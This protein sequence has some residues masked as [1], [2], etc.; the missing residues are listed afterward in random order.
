MG[1]GTAAQRARAGLARAAKAIKRRVLELA[2]ATDRGECL[3]DGTVN[4]D[5][6]LDV[7]HVPVLLD[8]EDEDD[9]LEE[10]TLEPVSN[11]PEDTE[12]DDIVELLPHETLEMI[13]SDKKGEDGGMRERN[14]N[15]VLKKRASDMSAKE[16]K[17]VEKN[18]ALGYNGQSR[19]WTNE[20]IR[21]ARKQE[22]EDAKTRNSAPAKM[23]RQ[24]FAPRPKPPV[25]EPEPTPVPSDSRPTSPI[26]VYDSDVSDLVEYDGVICSTVGWLKDAS[27]TLEY[28]KNYEGYW[29]GELFIKQIIEKIIP[30]FEAAHGPGHQMLFMI[31]NSQGHS[32]Y[33][34]DA[35]V[36]N[37]MNLN[38]GGKQAL[39]RPGWFIKDG[40]TVSQPMVFEPGHASAGKA[41]GM[42]AV[43]Q[44]RGLWNPSLKMRCKDSCLT[45]SCCAHSVLTHE[46]D[47]QQQRSLVQE[48]IENARHLCIILPKYHCE[49]NFIE[50]FWGA[51]KRYLRDNCDYSFDTLRANMPK[52]LESVK[53]STIRKW[54]HRTFRWLEAYSVGLDA[55]DAQKRVKEFSSHR[56]KSHRRVPES[57]AAQFDE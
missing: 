40:R 42:K 17:K 27:Q 21:K 48:T 56:Y 24:F 6:T 49:L 5:A 29:N 23:M 43:L 2:A 22:E 32:A 25:P 1:N 50:F 45:K 12:D 46:P 47:F 34:E 51:V 44:E 8:I 52:A 57:L 53:L 55:K 16:W 33:A 37:R 7:D 35:L 36:V 38:P 18:R 30:A 28:G 26:F 54:E 4:N 13:E 41:K 10:S 31:D 9:A 3:W 15:E 14:V 19:S 20:T 39:M 11:P